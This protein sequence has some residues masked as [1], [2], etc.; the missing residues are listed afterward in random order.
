MT[1]SSRG[2][3]GGI[4]EGWRVGMFVTRLFVL[5]RVWTESFDVHVVEEMANRGN[6]TPDCQCAG[7]L[8]GRNLGGRGVAHPNMQGDDPGENWFRLENSME[9]TRA[10]M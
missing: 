10:L 7:M 1:A 4:V 6:L 8:H 9:E 2:R 5:C 3:R